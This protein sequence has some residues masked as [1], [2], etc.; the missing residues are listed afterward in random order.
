MDNLSHNDMAT[1]AEGVDTNIYMDS[2]TVSDRCLI[3]KA[4]TGGN[5]VQVCLAVTV[6][7][8]GGVFVPPKL[9]HLTQ[10]LTDDDNN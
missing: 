10:F 6:H 9:F 4:Q 5:G 8:Q 3:L 1:A 7:V 2:I